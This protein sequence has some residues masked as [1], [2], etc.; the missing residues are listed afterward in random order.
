[1]CIYIYT[2]KSI[3][4]VEIF[5]YDLYIHTLLHPT[6]PKFSSVSLY[7]LLFPRWWALPVSEVKRSDSKN[8][9]MTYILIHYYTLRVQNVH[10]FCSISYC[11]RDNEHF[12]FRR[13]RGQIRKICIWPIYSYTTTPYGSQIFICFALSLTVSEIMIIQPIYIIINHKMSY[14]HKQS[15]DQGWWYMKYNKV[16][17][18]TIALWVLNFHPF[19][20][21]SHRFRDND[22]K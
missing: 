2:F 10:P 18:Y 20:S 1:M 12:L 19:R 17:M 8:L 14:D 6:G 15:Y 5:A 7:F 13:S 3:P 9:H 16:Y 21:I 22:Q 4:F 11:F